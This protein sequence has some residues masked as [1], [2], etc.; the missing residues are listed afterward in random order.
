M[1]RVTASNTI[2][3]EAPVEAVSAAIADY[4]QVRPRIQPEQFSAYRLI[5]GGQGDGTVAAWNLQATKKRSRD[6][7]ANVTVD[8]AAAHWSLVEKDENSSMATTYTVRETTGGALVEMTTSWDGAGGVGG[9]FERTFAP[10]GLKRIQHALLS[11]L[12]DDL[13]G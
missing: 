8:D 13:E 5:Q 6:V 3:I 12:K 7:K 9:F 1:A 4:A 10:A 2:V 11:N